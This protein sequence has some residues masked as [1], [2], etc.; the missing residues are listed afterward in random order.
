MFNHTNMQ[1]VSWER[2]V[3]QEVIVYK[4][5]RDI[6]EGEELCISYGDRL[7]FEDA[8]VDADGS[9]NREQE[10]GEDMLSNIQID[11]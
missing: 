11:V 9:M 6:A 2:D 7:W 1:N 10:N 5:L 8:D 3:E 4:T